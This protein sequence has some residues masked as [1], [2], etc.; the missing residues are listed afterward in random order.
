VIATVAPAQD[1]FVSAI[2]VR[3]V[4]VAIVALGGGRARETDPVDHAVGLSEVVALGE[5][6]GPGSDSRP[7]AILHA[8]DQDSFDQAAAA[9]R[10][11]VT[12]GDSPVAGGPEILE[13]I[14]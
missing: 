12:V 2:D 10:A 5:A 13:V 7:L 14:R 3:A 4:G 1:G 6:V 9:L 11:A 8:R